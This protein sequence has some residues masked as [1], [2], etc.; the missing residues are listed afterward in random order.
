MKRKEF[1][2]RCCTCGALSLLGLYSPQTVSGKAVATEQS[3]SDNIPMNKDQIK[4]LM[5]FIDE[6]INESD[7]A[8]IFQKLGTECFHSRNTESWVNRFKDNPDELFDG[9]NRGE[10]KYWEKL[11]YDKEKSV[12]RLV[13]REV[14]A[15]ACQYSQCEQ[16]PESLCNYCCKKFQEEIF[17][18]LLNKKVNVRIDESFILGS[19]RC[20]TTIF[21]S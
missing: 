19:N 8:K 15:C 4:A 10:S 3:A 6:S 21:V 2:D 17:E 20:S 13:G 12:I 11:E 18:H 7:K 5:K 1:I 16:P 14:S 9:V